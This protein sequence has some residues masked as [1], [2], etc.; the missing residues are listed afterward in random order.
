MASQGDS[1][2]LTHLRS[3]AK[4]FQLLPLVLSGLAEQLEPAEL[5]FMMGSHAAE[6]MHLEC[7]E[8]LF[9]RFGLSESDLQC[10]SSKHNCSGK[11][12]GMLLVCQKHGW[13]L[14]SYLDPGHP[15]Q[16]WIK[17]ILLEVSGA[18]ESE[19]I[20]G[21]DG[22][23]APTFILPLHRISRLY[24]QLPHKF[25]I[26]FHSGVTNPE[27]T[28]GSRRFENFFMQ[29]FEGRLFAKVGAEGVLALATPGH[30]IAIK[31]LDGD[32][33]NQIR[34]LI[35]VN[36]LRALGYQIP[37]SLERYDNRPIL[38]ARGLETG[39]LQAQVN[40]LYRA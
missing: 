29:A 37:K 12:L 18:S 33:S 26:L 10:G 13:P 14:E 31:I 16:T 2:C 25:Q 6:P 9:E 24:A 38:N 36:V 8:H 32:A 27:M 11:H 17:N 20:V 39:C 34:P 35:A 4:P 40:L 23:S 7:L 1:S 28:S 3:A 30:G 15:L 22:C 5:A 19:L 21:I